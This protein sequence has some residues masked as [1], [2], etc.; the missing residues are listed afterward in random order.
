MHNE[1]FVCEE[2]KFDDLIN[3]EGELAEV[4][5]KWTDKV[6]SIYRENYHM[7]FLSG[8]NIWYLE[9]YLNS[10]KRME[11]KDKTVAANLLRLMGKV[12]KGLPNIKIFKDLEV[13]GNTPIDRLERLAAGLKN[14]EDVPA[15]ALNDSN[16]FS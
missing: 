14:M 11:K 16:S 7:T 13:R 9:G 15:A 1:I 12:D 8:D 3:F 5:K 10:D 6:Q 2:S 4:L